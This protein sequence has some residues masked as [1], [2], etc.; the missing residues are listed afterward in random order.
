MLFFKK[1][2]AGPS[3][4]EATPREPRYKC[5]VFVSINGFEGEAVLS[6]INTSGYCMKSKT[7]AALVPGDRHTM[8]IR[9]ESRSGI[10]PF[11]MGVEVRWVKSTETWFSAGFLVIERPSDRSFEKYIKYV[12]GR[13]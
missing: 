8:Q 5:V 11:E 13:S 6:N 12:K 9:P 7:Y 2:G 3:D 10:K 4:S 1:R